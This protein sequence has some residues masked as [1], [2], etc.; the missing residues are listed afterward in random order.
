MANHPHDH[1]A[2]TEG[3]A[4]DHGAGHRNGH[5]HGMVDPSI[6]FTD[7]GLWA[8]KWSFIGLIAT[9]AIQTAVVLFSGSVALLADTIHNFGDAATA[10]PLGAASGSPGAL[11]R[12]SSRTVS[13]A[14][15]IWRGSRSS[16]RFSPV[17]SPPPTRPSTASC[18]PNRWR[19]SGRSWLRQ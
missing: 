10:V 11:R 4:H 3:D 8:L 5:A 12:P 14:S 2:G 15:R 16:L 6:A 7:R 19:C 18:T 9:A 13:A 1:E 17:P